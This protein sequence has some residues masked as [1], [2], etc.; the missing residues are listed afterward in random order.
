[1][2]T[3]HRNRNWSD[4]FLPD[5][6]RIV[7]SHLL[8]T[9]PDALDWHEATD[10]VMMDARDIR[11]AARVRR[12]GFAQRYPNQFTVRASTRNGGP[13]ELQKIVNGH[14]DWMFYGHAAPTGGIALWQLIDLRA[15]RAA[16][17]RH[18]N[19]GPQVLWGDKTNPDGTS[20][21]WFDAR[22]FPAYP[23]LVV[24]RSTRMAA[25]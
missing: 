17:I 9:A 24:A 20:F 14:G 15:F 3:Y 1:M 22:S 7:G 19:G 21:R 13:S 6:K 11:V 16:L 25:Q 23:P 2:N 12:P 4:Q 8:E 5:I 18:G 10:L